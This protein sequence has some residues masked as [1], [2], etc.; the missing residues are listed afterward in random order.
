MLLRTLTVPI[1]VMYLSISSSALPQL[2]SETWTNRAAGG[3]TGTFTKY[4]YDPTGLQ[5]QKKVFRSLDSNGALISRMGFAYDSRRIVL[6]DTFF[7]GDD[8]GLMTQYWYGSGINPV[9]IVSDDLAGMIAY[10]DSLIYNSAG[11][12]TERRRFKSDTLS[13]LEKFH[14]DPSGHPISKMTF[15][16]H[17]SVSIP[18]L[19]VMMIYDDFGNLITE[20]ASR[21]VDG[22]WFATKTLEYHYTTGLLTRYEEFEGDG[23]TGKIIAVHAFGYDGKGRKILEEESDATGK[24]RYSIAF[25]WK[26]VPPYVGLIRRTA[27]DYPAKTR[28]M[29]GSSLSSRLVWKWSSGPMDAMGRSLQ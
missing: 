13:F 25:A 29:P 8:P 2:Q 26:D 16:M 15:E 24:T 28:W 12:L 18:T 14:V 22:I 21:S 4:A 17:A 5:I 3:A 11:F 7:L 19:A 6:R 9:A 23:T 1:T 27:A 10:R 20:T